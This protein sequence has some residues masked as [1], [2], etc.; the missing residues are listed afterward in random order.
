MTGN[1]RD[2]EIIRRICKRITDYDIS[3]SSEKITEELFKVAAKITSNDWVICQQFAKFL[4]QRSEH[5]LAFAWS[6]HALDSNPDYAPLHHTKGNVLRSWGV[7]LMNEGN[8]EEAYQKF[9]EARESF[10]RSRARLEQN[11]YGYVTHLHMLLYLIDKEDDE[12]RKANLIAEGVQLYSEGLREVPQEH[13]NFL[14]DERFQRF[15]LDDPDSQEL[16]NK[17]LE[18]VRGGR[19]SVHAAVFA[20]QKLYIQGRYPD[21]IDILSKQKETCDKGVLVWVKEAELHAREGNFNE[22]MKCI[23]SARRRTNFTENDEALWAL[24]Y[25]NLL[26]ATALEDFREA[27]AATMRINESGFYSR[28][29]FP[30][31]YFWNQTARGVDPKKRSFKEHAK[32]WSGRVS[33]IRVGEHYGQ[34]SITDAI[35]ETLYVGF[36]PRYFTRKDL[37]RGD[38]INF[39]LTILRSRLRADEITSRPFIDTVDDLFVP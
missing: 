38:N 1:L 12:L 35:G 19:A 5:E 25:W 2:L 22:A 14:L 32:I 39:V 11:E 18:A 33:N 29:R 16:L 36:N 15:N 13:F 8:S 6:E 31:G 34:I 26:I 20:A 3:L 30:R 28:Q 9:N 37:R 23:D 27:R 21:A 24:M 4:L 7:K 10:A 17:I